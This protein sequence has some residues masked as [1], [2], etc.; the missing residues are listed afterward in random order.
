MMDLGVSISHGNG[1]IQLNS[2]EV[3]TV[4]KWIQIW[5]NYCQT[6]VIPYQYKI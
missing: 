3:G 6:V 5:N 1:T 4:G 2:M